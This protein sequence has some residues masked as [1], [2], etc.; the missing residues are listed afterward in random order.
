MPLLHPRFLVPASLPTHARQCLT[1]IWLVTPFV[2]PRSGRRA[3]SAAGTLRSFPRQHKAPAVTPAGHSRQQILQRPHRTGV[4]SRQM[5]K[6]AGQPP[7]LDWASR[8][9]T[10]TW[11]TCL[12]LTLEGSA[13][14]PLLTA[15]LLPCCPSPYRPPSPSG[16]RSVPT[17][18]S[19]SNRSRPSWPLFSASG[20]RFSWPRSRRASSAP[21]P[22]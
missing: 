6:F 15:L 13:M 5:G 9:M 20:A 14:K 8:L 21:S 22:T 1:A 19:N 12:Q 4:G 10:P 7:W 2:S 3:A 17:A 16:S 18:A 11:H